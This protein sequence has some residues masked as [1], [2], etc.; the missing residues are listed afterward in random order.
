M[1]L[2]SGRVSTRRLMSKSRRRR[3][4]ARRLLG[5]TMT[6]RRWRATARRRAALLPSPSSSTVFALGRSCAAEIRARPLSSRVLALIG[7]SSRWAWAGGPAAAVTAVTA[8]RWT[9]TGD[10]SCY[11]FRTTPAHLR[12]QSCSPTGMTSSLRFGTSSP[13][14][15]SL[16]GLAAS[17]GTAPTMLSTCTP[18]SSRKSSRTTQ[19]TRRST[20]SSRSS[21]RSKSRGTSS[22]T[23]GSTTP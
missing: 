5:V 7:A 15:N 11:P 20:P 14:Y 16:P 18:S 6:P 8:L 3:V 21:R 19:A 1:R 2:A 17:S 13:G 23:R 9:S 12:A 22:P 4:K 10:G